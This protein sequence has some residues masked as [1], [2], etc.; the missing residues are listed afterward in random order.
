[1][2]KDVVIAGAIVAACL[3]LVVVAFVIPKQKAVVPEVAKKEEP[4][5]APLPP[6]NDDLIASK[7]SD[8]FLLPG[9]NSQFPPSGPTDQFTNPN[10][11]H[12]PT[13]YPAPGTSS[14]QPGNSFNQSGSFPRS[15]SVPFPPMNQPNVVIEPPPSKP[16]TSEVKTHV[17]TA[18][19]TLGEISQKYYGTGKNW[20][21]IADANK[22]D[23][24]ELKVGQKLT[25]PAIETASTTATPA[26]ELASG[27]RNYTV[28][29]N[30]SYYSIAKKELGNAARWKE[31]EKLNNVPADELR[32]GKVI[33]LPAKA[34]AV[35][36]LK[37]GPEA[38]AAGDA[39][40]HVVK[41]GET[42]SDISKLHYGTTTKW[43]EIVKANPGIDPEGLKVGQKIKLPEIA[44]APKVPESGTPASTESIKPTASS[45]NPA[46]T[47]TVK[48][49]DTPASIAKSQM[50]PK[51]DWKKIVEANPGLD[52][53]KMRIGQKLVIPGKSA[54]AEPAPPVFPAAK[55]TFNPP[56]GGTQPA[57]GGASRPTGGGFPT[58]PASGSNRFDAP[59]NTTG[60]S[61]YPQ[62][63]GTPP[64]A[65]GS[66]FPT[67]STNNDAFALPPATT[68]P[69][70]STFPPS[71]TSP[72]AGGTRTVQ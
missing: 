1:M 27:E 21:K 26:P 55:P 22:V 25:I 68:F 71:T 12:Q 60:G 42:L 23:P 49:G 35:E 40:V 2:S 30:D 28:Q 11:N 61:A 37:P 44:G 9:N 52:P 59:L 58:P 48:A 57:P 4:V 7:P 17:V 10:R 20:K 24:S 8:D 66:N 56:F 45:A 19:E 18:G 54:P 39:N 36:A 41:G 34:A 16:A 13:P 63:T 43:K 64:A 5:L 65:P 3:G 33:K 62:P 51:G 50:G 53:N 32:V 6:S 70:S 67:T 47:Y 38:P 29:K 15:S 46:A 14:N 69:P 31:L 72:S